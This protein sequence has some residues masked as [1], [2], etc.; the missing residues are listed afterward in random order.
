MAMANEVDMEMGQSPLTSLS[1]EKVRAGFVQK[2][3]GILTVQ[4]VITFMVAFPIQRMGPEWVRMNKS[5]VQVAM[6]TSLAAVLGVSCCCAQ[7]A[8]QVPYNYMFLLLVTVCEAVIVGFVSAMYT[9]Q[10]VMI[11]VVLTGGIF[12]CLTIYAFTS[13][14][15]FTGMGGYLMAGLCGLMLTSFVCIFFPYS[16][17]TQKVMG[18][19]GA[20][21]FSFYIVYD[22]QLICG[23]K[24]KTHEFGVD[25]YVF[26][27]LNIY[28]D[29]INLFLYL[30][31]LF[32]DR[33]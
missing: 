24:H 31:S 18:G 21:L 1:D 29:I 26:A 14:T 11:S 6:F 16:P 32:G 7:V 33:E 3:Y 20:I 28:L 2:V 9:A 25:D 19:L 10:S 5:M 13:K 8:R 15:D 12:A 30:L 22:T 27:A 4:L 17:M 23:G